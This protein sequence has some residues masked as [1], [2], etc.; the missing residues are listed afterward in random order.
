MPYGKPTR[1]ADIIKAMR[2]YGG[3][4]EVTIGGIYAF[5]PAG[6][7]LFLKVS[8]GRAVETLSRHVEETR[9]R[10]WRDRLLPSFMLPPSRTRGRSK[11]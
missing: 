2:K 6:Q 5:G 9:R 8:E 7:I 11:R 10:L 3:W 1:Q 4:I